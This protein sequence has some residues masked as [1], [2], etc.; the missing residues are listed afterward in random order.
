MPIMSPARVEALVSDPF[1]R[2]A[3]TIGYGV[4]RTLV[5]VIDWCL[6]FAHRGT[7]IAAYVERLNRMDVAVLALGGEVDAQARDDLRSEIQA[8]KG[9]IRHG[10]V[11]PASSE[12]WEVLRSEADRAVQGR[13]FRRWHDLGAALG[14]YEFKARASWPGW[15]LPDLA[16]V[17][18]QARRVYKEVGPGVVPVLGALVQHAPRLAVTGPVRL[19][20]L[21]LGAEKYADDYPD[22]GGR[23]LASG[24]SGEL[25]MEL[26]RQLA[27]L[28]R[29]N[30]ALPPFI[31]TRHQER[32]LCEVRR[33]ALTADRLQDILDMDRAQM[34]RDVINPLKAAGRLANNRRLGGYYDPTAPPENK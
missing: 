9:R 12:V 1:P 28:M 26:E 13:P 7:L 29:P 22:G 30:P 5:C 24:L 18:D 11:P 33:E 27:D 19:L 3:F 6:P 21:V 17:L 8:L 2:A 16:A 32:A 31:P 10:E 14:R 15:P 4:W 25:A 20:F 23:A 34:F